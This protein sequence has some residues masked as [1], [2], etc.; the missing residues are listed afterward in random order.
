MQNYINFCKNSEKTYSLTS[1]D[2]KTLE[3]ER[4]YGSLR[5]KS[6]SSGRRRVKRQ[7]NWSF[8]QMQDM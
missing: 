1:R 3:K 4:R 5:R 6:A 2:K 8:R 7:I